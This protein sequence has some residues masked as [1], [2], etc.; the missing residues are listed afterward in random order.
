MATPKT[1]PSKLNANTTIVAPEGRHLYITGILKS[2]DIIID[3][4]TIGNSHEMS[5]ASP[6]QCRTFTGDV[7]HIA[8]YISF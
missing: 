7:G 4:I 6:I 3:G 8:Y 1:I 5:F 2:H